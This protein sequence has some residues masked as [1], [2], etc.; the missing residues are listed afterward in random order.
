MNSIPM[1][2]GACAE[3]F[4]SESMMGRLAK[5]A[6]WNVLAAVISR[7][8]GLLSSICVAR[9]LGKEAFGELGIIQSTVGMFGVLAGLGLGLTST[10]Y[11]AQ[12][13][14]KDPDRAGRI[15][16]LCS[17][18]AL[19][20]G[21]AISLLLI[22]AAPWLAQQSLSAPHLGTLL[23]LSCPLLILSALNGSQTGT[24]AGFE[25]FSR[26]ARINLLSGLLTLPLVIAGAFIGQT[27]G[28]VWALTASMAINC[29]LN[30]VAV[31]DEARRANINLGFN[32]CTQ[33]W[34][35]LWRFSLPAMLGSIVI[36]PV[37]WLCA[38]LLVNQP[39]GYSEM[40]I[41]NA[42]NQWRTAILFLP[43]TLCG[44]ALPVLSSLAGNEDR[45]QYG[46][47]FNFSV[48]LN[49]GIAL[50]TACLIAALSTLLMSTFGPGFSEGGGVLILLACSAVF[51][52]INQN[53]GVALAS[54][55]QL[56]TGLLC[57]MLWAIVMI[58]VGS[59]WIRSDGAFGLAGATVIAYAVQSISLL[60]FRQRDP[61]SS[62]PTAT[63][64]HPEPRTAN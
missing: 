5:G 62:L 58:G 11:V 1:V 47:V 2:R 30:R 42:A 63:S 8:M 32:S 38:A 59:I 24:L 29:C 19:L 26:I 49:G 45:H 22:A 53:L 50:I 23:Q 57:N 33:E 56:W 10:K 27:Q 17:I 64:K 14:E 3:S 18:V 15:I 6:L 20:S 31:Q 40:G 7:G 51:M 36:V 21:A 25:A 37:N 28:V 13:R 43:A 46:R 60:L 55:E 44:L 12:F 35:I 61:R 4:Q 41:F 16:A 34:N 54:R 9:F 39:N 48:G 52:A